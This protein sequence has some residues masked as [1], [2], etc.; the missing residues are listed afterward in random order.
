MKI[1]FHH[2]TPLPII[3]YGGI[4]R[5]L[6]WHMKELIRLGHQVVLL[7]HP[8]SKVTN[9]GINLIPLLPDIDWQTLIPVDADIIHLNIN[10]TVPGKIP[11]I[12]TVHG[13][14]KVAEIFTK[15]SVFVSKKHAEIHG[16]DQYI[17]N[18]L[19][20]TEYPFE[21]AEKNWNEFLF[22][23]KASWRV[24]N[25]SHAVS[26]CRKALKHLHIIGGKWWGFSR[27]I[28]NHG[29]IGGNQKLQIM[30]SCDALIFPVRW[31]EP[32][33]IAVIEAMSQGLPVIGSPYGSLPELISAEVGLIVQSYQ[34]LTEALKNPPRTF[35]PLV[36]RK[37]VEDNFSITKHSLA[38]LALYQKVIDGKN[39]NLNNPSYIFN[40]RAED[41]LPF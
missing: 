39:L 33:G 28:H 5:I 14:G 30:R 36:V 10:H 27:F 19:D 16:S 40:T 37:Y 26:S 8:D 15:N 34:E 11:T 13:N 25:L 12:N 41:L 17:H 22:L 7:G 32:F 3:G 29:I 21:V 24:K 23:A 38:Y 18:A 20:L 9:Y 35:S 2:P 6:F 1:V 4:E 31:H